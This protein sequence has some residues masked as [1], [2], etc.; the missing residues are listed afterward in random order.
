MTLWQRFLRRGELE[1]QLAREL[2]FHLDERIA[3]LRAEGLPEAE[4]RRRALQELGGME[5]AKEACRDARGTLWLESTLQDIRYA[6]RTLRKTPAFTLAAMATLA[7]GIGANTAIFQ[8]LD[9]VR[10]RSLPAADPGSLARIRIE[11]GQGFGITHYPDNLSY[12]L[13]EQIREHQRG[14]S[15]IIAWDSGYMSERIGQGA[16]MRS[17]RALHV[18]GS[19]FATLG[20][21]PAAGRLIRLE[22]DVRGCPAPPVVL[23][24]A[25]WQSEFGG[26]ASAI[27]SRLVVGG[28]PLEIVGV[29]PAA[30][31]GPE[32]GTRFDIALPLCSRIALHHGD[33]ASY[34]RRDYFWLNLMGR[35]KPGWNLARAS[36]QLQAISPGIVRATLP[37]GYSRRSLDRYLQFRLEALPGATGVSRLRDEYDRSLWLLLG[38]AALVLVI[39]CANL[40]NLVLARAGARRREFAVRLAL[41]ASGGRLVRQ[42][43]A[44]N[45]LLA[46]SGALLGLALAGVLS[47]A[48]LGFLG[49]GDSG[50]DLSLVL[51]WRMLAFTAVVASAT[52]I[53]LG[54]APALRALRAHPA[55]AVQVGGRGHTAERG[56]S[57]FQRGLVVA[58]VAVSLV[59]VTGAFLFVGSFRRLVTMDPGFRAEGVVLAEFDMPRQEPVLRQL[60]EEVRATPQVESA[61]ATTNFLIGSGSWSLGIRSGGATANQSSPG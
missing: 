44:E 35:L 39:A 30:F 40:S 9:A 50:P 4:A 51:D 27:G 26:Q 16:Q 33:T 55:T 20:I 29:A 6:A 48:I 21:A 52:C 47:R 58:Q 61:A 14:F 41:G 46:L 24:Y 59:L 37:T 53:L 34:D 42:S 57:G 23:G 11:N 8:L 7:L 2:Q 13:F 5:Q 60:L 32:V 15:G 38:L 19:F 49:S 54:L 1:R 3:A 17:V 12:P 56:Q 36:Q 18:D 25:F 28:L 43:L 31:T 22:D 10:L 45:L